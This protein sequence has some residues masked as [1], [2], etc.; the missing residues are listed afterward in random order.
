MSEADSPLQETGWN[1]EYWEPDAYAA[2]R[3][4]AREKGGKAKDN[5][6]DPE[7][8]IARAWHRGFNFETA[9]MARHAEYVKQ[10]KARSQ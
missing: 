10:Q 5:P 6:H 8:L 4:R 1:P 2:G 3:Q 9:A 7:T